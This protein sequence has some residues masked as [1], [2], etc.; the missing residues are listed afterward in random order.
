MDSSYITTFVPFYG[1]DMVGAYTAE[2]RPVLN[3]KTN[4]SKDD[5]NINLPLGNTG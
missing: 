5:G 3:S 4:L 2:L 1:A